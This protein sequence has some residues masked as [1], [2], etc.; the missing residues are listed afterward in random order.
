MLSRK[1]KAEA[2]ETLK[3]KFSR[4]KG[5]VMTDYKGMTVEEI[6]DLR[7][8]FRKADVEYK[9]VK[10]TLARIAAEGTPAEAAR[11]HFKGPIG[12]ALSYTDAA[13]V[14]KSALEFSKKNDK[15]KVMGGIIEGT[16]CEAPALKRIADLPSREVLLSMMAG[17]FQAP[18]TKMA[19]LLNAT[20]V[21]FAYALGALK[22]KKASGQ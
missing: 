6:T 12:L 21:R 2:V 3:D 7:V 15:L 17:T 22:E 4:A 1:Q 5:L 14:A 16:F 8:E 10:N 19:R 11:D 13:Q 9:V 18:A 20:V